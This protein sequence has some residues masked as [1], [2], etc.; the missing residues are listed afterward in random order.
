MTLELMDADHASVMWLE[1][2]VIARI[3]TP[4]QEC[5]CAR[6]MLKAKTANDAKLDILA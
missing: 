4:T 2:S 6:K 3:V 5:V 1:V